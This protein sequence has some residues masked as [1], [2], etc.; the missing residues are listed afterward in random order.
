[1]QRRLTLARLLL[2]GTALTFNASLVSGQEK[3][4]GA[5]QAKPVPKPAARDRDAK[6]ALSEQ[7]CREYAQKVVNAVEAGDR[8]ALD[9]LIDFESIFEAATAGFEV[10]DAE[11]PEMIRGLHSSM[12]SQGGL[13]GQLIQN[14]Q[15][16]GNFDFLRVRQN[17][18]RPVIL[19]RIIQP[20]SSGGVGYYEFVPRRSADDKIRSVDIYAFTSGEYVSETMRR[21]LLPLVADRSRTFLDKLLTGER[22]YV[23]DFPKFQQI[24]DIAKEGKWREA[25]ALLKELRPETKRQKVVLLIRLRA[26]QEAGEEKEYATALEEFRMLFPK[27]PCLE[28]LSI[29]YYTQRKEYARALECIDGLDKSVGGDPYLNVV[30]AGIIAERGDRGKARQ[31]ANRAI[32]EEPTLVTAYLTLVA[33][34]LE[35]KTYDETLTLLKQLDQKFKMEFNDLTTVPEYAGF[36]K[37]PQYKH[38][39]QYLEQ[40]GKDQKRPRDQSPTGCCCDRQCKVPRPRTRSTLWM[41]TT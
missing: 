40:K 32:A 16:G 4:E 36:V 6:S 31:L 2:V 17:R 23:R 12:G 28:L 20:A 14:S 18:Q 34:S 33:I 25:L 21:T 37:S 39:I 8:N 1:M 41:P 29:E 24:V 13:A 30:R 10:P 11:R 3:T 19:F 38:W 15:A 22:D 27:D 9:A 7:D 26:A 35:D 5:I